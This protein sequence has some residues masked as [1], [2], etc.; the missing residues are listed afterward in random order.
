MLHFMLLGINNELNTE[1][2]GQPYFQIIGNW[3][4]YSLISYL[5]AVSVITNYSDIRNHVFFI[6]FIFL[7][8]EYKYKKDVIL[9]FIINVHFQINK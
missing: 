5:P 8:S 2:S 4:I 6:D 3:C 1:S 7:K 9:D